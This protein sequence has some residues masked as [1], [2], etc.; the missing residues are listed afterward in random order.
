MISFNEA[1]DSINLLATDW[2]VES[3]PL[4]DAAGRVISEPVEADREY[5]PFNRAA[6]DGYAVRSGDILEKGIREFRVVGEIF[7]GQP[8]AIVVQSGEAVKIMTGAP[9]PD[10]AD[11]VI[12][13]EDAVETPGGVAFH[14]D[15]FVRHQ[16]IAKKGG[17]IAHG[18]VIINNSLQIGTGEF[19]VLASLGKSHVNVFRRPRVALISTGDEILPVGETP[20]S[21]QIRDANRYSIAG[22][23]DRFRIRPMFTAIVRDEA[24]VLRRTIESALDNDLLI[25]SG[26]VSAGDADLVPG[27]L[28]A[29]G[30]R[31]QFHR[32]KIKPGK[33]LWVGSHPRGARVFAL[34]GNPYSV[35][36]ACRLF[37]DPF[38]RAC[39]HLPAQAPLLLPMRQARKKQTQ[40]DE[41]FPARIVNT[42][43]G[44]HAEPLA[45][46]SSGDITASLGTDGMV[47]HPAGAG[48][49]RAEE[50]VDLYLWN[51]IR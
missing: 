41:F 19:S 28:A 46:H 37:I 11:A 43:T 22:M 17:D 16:C 44:A 38:L 32:V 18:G 24:E 14:V 8:A 50:I 12:K 42:A 10:T 27:I 47:R 1:I 20:A 36:A 6:M 49:L 35:Q 45:Y 30:V 51:S 48:D 3:V 21:Y 5:P 31:E 33:P 25:L 26:G 15:E 9:V 34:P 2:G 39:F 23:L 29:C 7:A 13:R 4:E 40:F